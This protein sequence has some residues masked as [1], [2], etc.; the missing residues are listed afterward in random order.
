VVHRRTDGPCVTS[1]R[2]HQRSG[3]E[4]CLPL[5][6]T[7]QRMSAPE[8]DSPQLSKVVA[9]AQTSVP[10]FGCSRSRE[11]PPGARA[12]RRLPWTRTRRR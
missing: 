7:E 5:V 9:V 6:G 12:Q 2:L 3:V 4:G 8:L 10:S 11:Q 1:G